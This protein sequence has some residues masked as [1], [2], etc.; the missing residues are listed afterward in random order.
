M[1]PAAWAGLPLADGAGTTAAQGAPTFLFLAAA[2][3]GWVAVGRLRGR[4]FGRVPRP[5]A[6]GAAGLAVACVAAALLLPQLLSPTPTSSRPHSTARL[7]FVAP[8]PGQVVRGSPASV[9]VRLRLTGGRIVPF[10]STHLVPDEGHVHLILD[11]GLVSM[12]LTLSQRLAVAPGTHTLVAQ[13]VAV[14]HAPFAPP[15]LARVTFRV[16]P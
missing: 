12:S 13:F 2:I 9:E 10:T 6:W 1:G 4:R 7:A 15:V 8:R 5:M 14:D 11:G 16:E 3:L